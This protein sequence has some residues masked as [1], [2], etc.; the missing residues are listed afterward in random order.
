MLEH[1]RENRLI[2]SR[3]PQYGNPGGG[4]L[5]LQ[6]VSVSY[7]DIHALKSVQ[8]G[9][10]RG[11]IIF[12]TGPSGAGKTTLLK[13]LAGEQRPTSG[14]FHAPDIGRTR[15][16]IFVSRVFQDLKL[17]ERQ[18]C[19]E[20]MRLAYDPG[21]YKNR[22]E[23]DQDMGELCRVLGVTDRMGLLALNANGGLRQKVA[24]I[25]ALLTKPDIL[26]ADEPT[27]SLDSDNTRRLFDLLNL[28][29]VKRGLTVVWATHNRDLVKKFTG[30]TI[31][32]DNGRLVYSGHACFI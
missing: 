9:I 25:R 23:F 2:R 29:N 27:S 30:R 16:K 10:H 15:N 21:I 24:M 4:V 12:I 6:D 32:L 26:L 20:N 5:E 28:Y 7:G 31:H 11:E 1:Q 19:E 18:T 3:K 17:I 22:N 13:V 8:M 14:N